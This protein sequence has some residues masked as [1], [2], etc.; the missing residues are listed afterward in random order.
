MNDQDMRDT[1]GI[2]ASHQAIMLRISAVARHFNRTA[3]ALRH[4]V[5]RHFNYP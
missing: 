3:A 2:P 5:K 1:F 4:S